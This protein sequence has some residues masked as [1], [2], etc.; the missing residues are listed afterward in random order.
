M[1]KKNTGLVRIAKATSYSVKG[2]IAAFKGEAA[3][4]QELL[5]FAVLIPVALYIDITV[6]ERLFL[7]FSLFLV[8]ITELLNSAIEVLADRV[9]TETNV[10][11][12]KSKDIASAAVFVSILLA[13][14]TWGAILLT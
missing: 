14:G 4:R 7:I 6:A 13:L 5:A 2:L 8:F 1:R 12:G 9:S 11:I 10:L 3:V